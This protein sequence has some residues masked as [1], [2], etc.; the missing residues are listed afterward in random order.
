[1]KVFFA[2]WEFLFYNTANA[3]FLLFILS[4][5][6]YVELANS[7][8]LRA[9]L[10]ISCG[11][12]ILPALEEFA[13]VALVVSH[14]RWFLDR[15]CTHLIVYEGDSQAKMYIG[16]W[17]DYETMMREKFG[18]D[19]TPHRVK[20]RTLKKSWFCRGDS[21]SRPYWFQRS[22]DPPAGQK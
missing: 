22:G 16:N 14:D 11:S 17:S 13:G 6:G 10:W 7:K 4:C 8:L 18:Q 21:A 19:L 3:F 2:K 5:A 20:Y 9:A 12:N 1:M 15:I